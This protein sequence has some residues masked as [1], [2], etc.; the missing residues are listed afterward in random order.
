LGID[1]N[2]KLYGKPRED[3]YQSQVLGRLDGE[4]KN[5]EIGLGLLKK[6]KQ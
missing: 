5:A 4:K 1:A 6:K 3:L 2:E